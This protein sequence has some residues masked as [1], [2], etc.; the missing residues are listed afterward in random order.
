MYITFPYN[1]K[2]QQNITKFRSLVIVHYNNVPKNLQ[3]K[4]KFQNH[5]L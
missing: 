1:K 4:Q 5:K 3:N 2:T